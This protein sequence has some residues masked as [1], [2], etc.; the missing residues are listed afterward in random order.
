[1]AWLWLGPGTP[2]SSCNT[3]QSTLHD[4]ISLLGGVE[5]VSKVICLGFHP[6]N[7]QKLLKAWNTHQWHSDNI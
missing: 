2:L 6:S 3:V 5:G 4:K 1:M 7:L